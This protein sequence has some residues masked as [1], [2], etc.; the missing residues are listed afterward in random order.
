MESQ[1][2]NFS[3][4]LHFSR[5]DPPFERQNFQF[6]TDAMERL[7]SLK[8]L[9]Y[10]ADYYGDLRNN[11]SNNLRRL[12]KPTLSRTVQKLAARVTS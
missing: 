4:R 12:K 10:R 6:I 3:S 5:E 8:T 2:S 7:V 1:V 9:A 11:L